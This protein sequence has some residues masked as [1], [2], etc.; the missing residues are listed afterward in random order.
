MSPP[1]RH[2]TNNWLSLIPPWVQENSGVYL[3][4]LCSDTIWVL[5]ATLIVQLHSGNLC[6]HFSSSA[7]DLGFPLYILWHEAENM[8]LRV[9]PQGAPGITF[10]L[11]PLWVSPFFPAHRMFFPLEWENVVFISLYILLTPWFISIKC[12]LL[13]FR[14]FGSSK[15]LRYYKSKALLQKWKWLFSS[16]LLW[17]H[18]SPE[19][20]DA[21][22]L[23]WIENRLYG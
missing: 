20:M 17:H 6:S 10:S 23:Y 8:R 9:H 13:I 14:G 1:Q 21:Y 11:L 18:L 2:I 7:S 15:Y 3:R 22:C 19:A 4:H 16:F 5:F 12:I